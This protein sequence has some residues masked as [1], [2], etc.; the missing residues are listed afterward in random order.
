MSKHWSRFKLSN[1]KR[2]SLPD[3]CRQL[4][5]LFTSR[6]VAKLDSDRPAMVKEDTPSGHCQQ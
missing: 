5:A 6:M 3:F 2:T 1:I 4:D